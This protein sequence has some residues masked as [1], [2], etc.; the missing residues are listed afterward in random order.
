MSLAVLSHNAAPAHRRCLGSSPKRRAMAL[1]VTWAPLLAAASISS[2]HAQEALRSALSLDRT[3][4]Y[5]RRPVVNL[6]PAAMHLGPVGLNLS[7]YERTTF[8]DNVSLSGTDPR[9]DTSLAAGVR[10]GLSWQPSAN[11]TIQFGSE[12]GYIGYLNK[13]RNG[14]LEVSPDSTLA[15][16]LTTGDVTWTVYDQLEYSRQVSADSSLANLASLPRLS[17]T[18]GF[19]TS[20]RPTV[21]TLETGYSHNITFSD[22]E[23]YEYLNRSSEYFFGRV[24]RSLF[25]GTQVG[26]DASGNLTDY[27]ISTQNNSHGFSV[28]AFAEWQVL[29]TL[30]LT[31]RGGPSISYYPSASV[32]E[33]TSQLN[34][35]YL[36]LEAAHQLTAYIHHSLSLNRDV[37]PGFSQGSTYVEQL[38]SSYQVSWAMTDWVSLSAFVAYETGSQPLQTVLPGDVLL[39]TAE[40]FT[41]TS[42]GPQVSWRLTRNCSANLSYSHGIRDSDLPGR[43]YRNNTVSLQLGYSL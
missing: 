4:E 14:G 31:A 3:L 42:F 9:S 29:R 23:A 43:S 18:A 20:W 35:Y 24:G 41:R 17:N 38:K 34:S 25:E 21:W 27:E 40:K 7:L 33:G 13:T 12:M 39:T 2:S 26:V 15:Y 28:G 22:T 10:F 36:G 37:Q 16:S 5:Q 32:G 8:D 1:P 11:S 19:R 6:Q 30:L